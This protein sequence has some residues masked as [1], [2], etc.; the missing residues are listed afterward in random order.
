MK[1]LSLSDLNRALVDQPKTIAERL[2]ILG[3]S[4]EDL[5][6]KFPHDVLSLQVY[7]SSFLK[8]LQ[9]NAEKLEVDASSAASTLPENFGDAFGD[10]V[11]TVGERLKALDIN[12]ADVAEMF[13]PDMLAVAVNG[14]EFQDFIVKNQE[15]FLEK[16]EKLS[17]AGG[18]S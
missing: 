15:K 13:S 17:Q 3:F 2:A 6:G 5:A 1:Q 14:D 16:F 11:M 7:G 18:D 12:D 10:K 8:F 4:A 9:E